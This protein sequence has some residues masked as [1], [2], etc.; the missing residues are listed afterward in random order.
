MG[1]AVA[2]D[3]PVDGARIDHL[4]GAEGVAV[5]ELAVVEIGDGCK[6][7]VGVGS[8][9]NSLA[10][11]E[12][13]RAGLIEENE[14]ADHL[15][16]WGR[17]CAANFKSAEV[18]GARND[19]GFDA[20]DRS[21]VGAGR[22]EGGVPAHRFVSP[23]GFDV[24]ADFSLCGLRR[25]MCRGSYAPGSGRGSENEQLVLESARVEGFERGW[26]CI[27]CGKVEVGCV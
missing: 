18:A 27:G 10:R 8:D 26:L 16:L 17:E 25:Y 11:D 12:L 14:G 13:G 15:P 24:R 9:V 22:F 20:V 3:H 21:S 1:D 7:D 4:V 5:L 19:H 2:S 23:A 6:A